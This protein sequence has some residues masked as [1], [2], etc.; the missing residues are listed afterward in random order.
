MDFEK[1]LDEEI[2]KHKFSME[3]LKDVSYNRIDW[4]KNKTAFYEEALQRAIN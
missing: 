3:Q 4:I 1:L 2:Q